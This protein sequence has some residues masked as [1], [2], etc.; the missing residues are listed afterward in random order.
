MQGLSRLDKL[1]GSAKMCGS[2]SVTLILHSLD[3]KKK[4]IVYG[5]E[6]LSYLWFC[7]VLVNFE[8]V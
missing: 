5:W 7:N 8:E 2:S 1:D 3:Q 4:R 6:F